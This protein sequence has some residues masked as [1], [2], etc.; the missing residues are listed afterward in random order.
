MDWIG[1]LADLAQDV[2]NRLELML[3]K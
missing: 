1:S 3:A 2:G